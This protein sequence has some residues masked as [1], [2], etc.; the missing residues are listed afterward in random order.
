MAQSVRYLDMYANVWNL[1]S[2]YSCGSYL[3]AN[4]TSCGGKLVLFVCIDYLLSICAV[5]DCIKACGVNSI[6]TGAFVTQGS[7]GCTCQ[8]GFVSPTQNG[9][10]CVSNCTSDSA[11]GTNAVCY[12]ASGVCACNY[13]FYSPTATGTNCIA[14]PLQ[15]K[16]VH[17]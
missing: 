3:G 11:C 8:P 15:C 13:G 12:V 7:Y 10:N 5:Y 17:A 1:L 6:C 14:A 16:Y 9:M 4:T 2:V